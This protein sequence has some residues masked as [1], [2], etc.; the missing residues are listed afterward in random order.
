MH[1]N[2]TAA[3]VMYAARDILAH[4]TDTHMKSNTHVLFF[5]LYAKCMCIVYECDCNETTAA[6]QMSSCHPR[7]ADV[8]RTEYRYSR[9]HKASITR[10]YASVLHVLLHV[11]G[12]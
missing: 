11:N 9:V 10:R 6:S 1:S 2:K 8:Q 7:A 12:P 3:I 5:I 4:I